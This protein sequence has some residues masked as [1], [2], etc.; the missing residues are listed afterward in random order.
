MPLTE[1]LSG[2]DAAFLALDNTRTPMHMGAIG[3][4]GSEKPVDTDRLAALLAFRAG[5]I[6]RLR[7]RVRSGLLP[8][9]GPVWQ[10]DPRF[11]A[12]RH[13][14]T[15]G[16]DN[17]DDPGALM[18][19]ASEWI[20]QPLPGG[21]ALWSLDVLT[22][23][24]DG[25]FAILLKLHHALTDGSGAV[26]VAAALLDEVPRGRSLTRTA[27]EPAGCADGDGE[28]I[29]SR[30]LGLV[31]SITRSIGRSVGTAAAT[32]EVGYHLVRA[33]RPGHNSLL[34]ARHS[35]A[36][37]LNFVRL[38]AGDLRRVRKMH[39]GTPNDIALAVLAGALRT[40]LEGRGHPVDGVM[41]RALIPVSLRGRDMERNG[42]NR[43][44]GYLCELPI[45]FDDPIERLRHIKAAMDRNKSAGPLT[46][47]GAIPL[48]ANQIPP[49]V[50]LLTTGLIG[51]AGNA[52]FDTVVTNVPLPG[53]PLALDGAPLR[54]SYPVVPLAPGQALGVAISPY[55]D[56]VHIGLHADAEAVPDL[57]ALAVAVEKETARLHELCN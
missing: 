22:G 38:D 37:L 25:D 55:R 9:D 54:A 10:L 30:A 42:G 52:L 36:R 21:Q 16:L 28:S 8:T 49:A 2:L 5:R 1:P 44:S 17:P 53:I 20:A 7:L 12:A 46:G 40:W 4:F 50:H 51:G 34:A 32:A 26:E 13:I 48:L 41:L 31:P 43:L 11:D 39:G 15:R 3:V 27:E 14:R 19:Y 18:R 33:I 45:G 24:P 23:L 47:A 56:A 57:D 29:A 35:D 6:D